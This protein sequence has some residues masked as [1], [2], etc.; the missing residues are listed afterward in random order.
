[1]KKAIILVNIGS[2]DEMNV[3]STRKYLR[4]FLM[5]KR[6]IDIPYLSRFI[7]VNGIIA[8]FRAPKSLKS[9]RQV[10]INNESPLLYYSFKL[11]EKLQKVLGEGYIVKNVMMYG[12]PYLNDVLKELQKKH[13]S[14]IIFI[15]LYPQYASSTT[16]SALEMFFN[17]IKNWINIPNI[18]TH[19][20]FF[21]HSEFVDLWANHIQKHLP[22][23]FD[24]IIFSYHGLP[25]RQIFKADNQYSH[26]HCNLNDCCNTLSDVNR[27]CYRANCIHTTKL[28]AS[29][30]NLPDNKIII[31]FQS[32]LG[33][34][35]WLKPYTSD[36]LKNEAQKGT[37]NLVIVSPAF[38]TD[39]LETL[40]ELGIEGKELF[41]NNGGERLTLIPSLNDKDEWVLFLKKLVE[42]N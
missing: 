37:K 4:K 30:L 38:V 25:E 24:K 26:H 12:R 19:H 32:R 27:F 23:H 2:P 33:Q 7:L 35:E 39:C 11:E 41:E 14:E 5:D 1:M 22:E 40:F 29:K 16:G 21:N 17:T 36:V 34:S 42:V 8:P 6:V 10:L 31:S 28:I 15:P 20:T 3:S 9:Y 13:L 18:K